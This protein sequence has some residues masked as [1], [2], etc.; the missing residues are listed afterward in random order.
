[1]KITELQNIVNNINTKIINELKNN[2]NVFLLELSSNGT[3]YIIKC[4][5]SELWCSIDDNLE[6]ESDL[7]TFLKKEIQKIIISGTK[8]LVCLI[9]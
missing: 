8:L 1:M 3:D 4:C 9:K 6:D 7:E 5:G 2:E